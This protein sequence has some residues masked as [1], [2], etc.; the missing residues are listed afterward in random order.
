V[1]TG[2]PFGLTRRTALLVPEQEVMVLPALGKLYP[3][4]LRRYLRQALHGTGRT[5]QRGR[6]HP[7]AQADLYGLRNFRYGDSPRWI[8]WRTTARKGELMVREFEEVPSEN[9]VVVLDLADGRSTEALPGQGGPSGEETGSPLEH[10]VSL[11]ATVCW[12][13][14]RQA[15]N[16]LALGVGGPNPVVLMGATSRALGLAMLGHLA[17]L[18]TGGSNETS[19]LRDRLCQAALPA[20][21]V[22]VV[23][24]GPTDLPDLLADD[25]RRPVASVD[26]LAGS[27]VDFFER[28]S[29]HA[30]RPCVTAE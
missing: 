9:L 17:G 30:T 11:V 26:V 27:D 3:G 18:D 12:E 5:R 28:D 4:R 2:F 22:L 19:H 14:C 15:G 29:R 1:A 23:S 7:S 6:P 8:H 16:W 21:P 24:A 25:L 20:A 10:A 13:W